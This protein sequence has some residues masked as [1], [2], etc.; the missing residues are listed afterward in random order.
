MEDI[1][2]DI[3]T[4][5]SKT[6]HLDKRMTALEATRPFLEDMVERDI[7][8]H[9]KLAATLQQVQISMVGL[10]GEMTAMKQEFTESNQKTNAEL[11]KVSNKVSMIE[12]K[13]KFDIQLFIKANWPWIMVLLGFGFYAVSRY[14][15]F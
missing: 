8:S 5:Y 10:N 4:L 1:K 3:D 15:K 14:A 11:K 12:E 7:K 13:G 6:N 2:K 9:E